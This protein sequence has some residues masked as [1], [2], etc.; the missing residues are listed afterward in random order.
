M[1]RFTIYFSVTFYFCPLPMHFPFPSVL[2][3]LRGFFSY[4]ST[5]LPI[6]STNIDCNK[7]LQ[8]KFLKECYI[9]SF[10]NFFPNG[11]KKLPEEST[12]CRMVSKYLSLY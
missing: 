11:C 12:I 3:L 10:Q 2:A 5:E 9:L 8:L 6:V 7:E 4:N 1:I